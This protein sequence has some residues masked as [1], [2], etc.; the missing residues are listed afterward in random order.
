MTN[1]T[2]LQ[3]DLPEE[4]LDAAEMVLREHPTDFDGGTAIGSY[5]PLMRAVISAVLESCQL[6]RCRLEMPSAMP[7]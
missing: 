6:E 3:I 1:Q 7:D 2:V 5:R 4:A